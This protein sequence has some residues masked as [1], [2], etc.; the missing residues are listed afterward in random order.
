[1]EKAEY[2]AF[3]H[4]I[5][6]KCQKGRSYLEFF[7]Q[8]LPKFKKIQVYKINLNFSDIQSDFY[9][10]NV[11]IIILIGE[12]DS[13][14]LWNGC[15]NTDITNQ[16]IRSMNNKLWIE[17]HLEGSGHSFSFQVRPLKLKKF[18]NPFCF[19]CTLGLLPCLQS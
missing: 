17:S 7:A 9:S 13:P 2:P 15:G 4:T 10:V 18:L 6:L 14:I 1:M 11:S 12:P 3:F 5:W 8:F 19:A 16:P